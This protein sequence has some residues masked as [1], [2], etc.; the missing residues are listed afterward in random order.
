MSLHCWRNIICHSEDEFP[1]LIWQQK[2]HRK[3][4]PLS[5]SLQGKPFP[6]ALPQSLLCSVGRARLLRAGIQRN[7]TLTPTRAELSTFPQVTKHSV[8][9]AVLF[10]GTG[11]GTPSHKGGISSSLQMQRKG[12]LEN[13]TR[14]AEEPRESVP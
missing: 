10:A 2:G 13:F 3:P 14:C 12:F 4:F 9:S 11:N 8:F 1:A 5:S 6:T 7:G